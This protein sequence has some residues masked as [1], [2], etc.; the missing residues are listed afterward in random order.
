[1]ELTLHECGSWRQEQVETETIQRVPSFCT[2][3]LENHQPVGPRVLGTRG[4]EHHGLAVKP[5]QLQRQE[6]RSKT[7]L[8]NAR[9]KSHFINPHLWSSTVCLAVLGAV[10]TRVCWGEGKRPSWG[11]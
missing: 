2:L 7:G 3:S 1:M 9:L 11:D 5:C 8:G 4:L 6:E 10:G